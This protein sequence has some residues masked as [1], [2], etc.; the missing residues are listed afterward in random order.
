MST[1]ETRYLARVVESLAES[2]QRLAEEVAQTRAEVSAARKELRTEISATRKEL[3]EEL[4]STR[5][6]LGARLVG[7]IAYHLASEYARVKSKGDALRRQVEGL[8]GKLEEARRVFQERFK[9]VL[10]DYLKASRDYLSQFLGMAEQEFYVLNK[11]LRAADTAEDVYRVVRP[12]WVNEELVKS[13]LELD[14]KS[15]VEDLASLTER[16]EEMRGLLL[17]QRES[18]ENLR[19]ISARYSMP[20]GL[21]KPGLVLYLPVLV[22]EAYAGSTKVTR[23]VTP[24]GTTTPFTERLAKLA[25]EVKDSYP[26]ALSAEELRL[27]S[28][29]LSTLAT[30]DAERKL[31]ERMSVKAG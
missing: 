21:A 30:S 9:G 31:F 19:K 7:I 3:A 2:L 6:E 4:V 23:V 25:L 24:L 10:S 8:R 28:K 17:S 5:R 16:L 11:L 22:V 29:K 27:I 15:R 12:E 20:G 14:V 13:V 1:E 26:R 18:L